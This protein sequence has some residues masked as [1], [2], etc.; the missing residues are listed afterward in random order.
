MREK[1]P[2]SGKNAKLYSYA[3]RK[4]GLIVGKKYS[5]LEYA[6]ASGVNTKTMH[7]RIRAKQC[8]IVTDYDLRIASNGNCNED[9]PFESRLDTVNSMISQEWLGRAII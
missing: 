8:K 6:E 1:H 4:A 2:N 9:K 5:L 3:G 7:S